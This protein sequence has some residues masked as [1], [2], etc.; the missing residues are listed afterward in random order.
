LTSRHMKLD[1]YTD[2]ELMRDMA[3][4]RKEAMKLILDRYMAMVSRSAYRILCDREDCEYVTREI[5]KIIWDNASSY[6]GRYPISIWICRIVCR[7]C[8]AR[9]RRR[10]IL[11]VL[12]I[13]PSVYEPSDPSALSSDE[14]YIEKETWA[15]F[16]RA[17][18]GFSTKQRIIYA[19]KELEGFSVFD[20]ASITGMKTDQ[21]RAD[22]YVA[23]KKVKQELERYGNVR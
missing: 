3:L 18:H 9:L 20:V 4:G 17:S 21:I 8:L 16:C 7:V 12:S 5:F 19:F 11:D 6:D 1:H 23:R 14:E 2:G 13:R 10:R 22:L 15:V